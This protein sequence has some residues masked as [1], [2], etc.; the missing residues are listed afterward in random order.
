MKKRVVILYEKTGMGHLR[1]TRILEEILQK[2]SDVEVICCAGSDL[3]H[4]T[5]VE[6]LVE[7]WNT[8][9]RKNRIRTVAKLI[10]IKHKPVRRYTHH[11]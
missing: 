11:P 1:M 2:Q 7:L 5:S 6:T 10:A 9:I 8:L 4:S 3:L